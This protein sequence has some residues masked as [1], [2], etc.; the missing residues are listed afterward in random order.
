MKSKP[1]AAVPGG[2]DKT[3]AI[4]ELVIGFYISG[5]RE[6]DVLKEFALTID[7]RDARR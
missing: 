5:R 3:S 6:Q 1:Q 2:K 7:K 4:L